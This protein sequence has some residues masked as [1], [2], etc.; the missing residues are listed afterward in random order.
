MARIA[1]TTHLERHLCCPPSEVT[2]S[3]VRA[4][5]EEVFAENSQLRSY[6]L[7]DQGALRQHVIIFLDGEAI[8]DRQAQSDSVRPTSEIYVLQALSGG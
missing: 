5:L 8:R 1:F 2:G 3:T 4:V 7:D 6:L